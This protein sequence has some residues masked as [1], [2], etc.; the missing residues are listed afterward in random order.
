MNDWVYDFPPTP[1]ADWIRQI[2]RDLKGKPLSSL[3]QEWWAGATLDPIHHA[4]DQQT[5]VSL[6]A[7]L[8]AAP[9]L[10]MEAIDA[11]NLNAESLNRRLL[12]ALQFGA[13]RITLLINESLL[14]QHEVWLQ[15]IYPD[16][17]T[18]YIDGDQIS[19]ATIN[20]FA[21]KAP[22]HIFQTIKRNK[23]TSFE[24]IVQHRLAEGIPLRWLYDIPNDGNWIEACAEV[25]NRIQNDAKTWHAMTERDDHLS[26]C[27]LHIEAATDYVKCLIQLRTLHLLWQNLAADNSSGVTKSIANN[28]L[29]SHIKPNT[30]ESPDAFLI[31]ATTAAVAAFLGGV[32]GLCIHPLVESSPNHYLR[33]NRNIHHLLHMESGLPRQTDTMAGAYAIDYYTAA[34]TSAIWEKLNGG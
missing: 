32:S 9:P 8:F 16:M 13:Q 25:F 14:D 2:E 3:H 15:G 21:S 4:D 26:R 33:I 20:R 23:D 31:R 12:E 19:A 22:G 5:R 1:K 30:G 10:I 27:E 29:F 7:H 6:P 28:Y 17:L 18:W 34:W 11:K 24:S